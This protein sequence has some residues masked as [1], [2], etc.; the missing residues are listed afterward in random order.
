MLPKK[1]EVEGWKQSPEIAEVDLHR[2]DHQNINGVALVI[3]VI[4]QTY[5]R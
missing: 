2:V 4:E 1:L 3:E 5:S